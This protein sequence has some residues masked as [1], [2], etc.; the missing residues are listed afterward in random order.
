MNQ[1]ARLRLPLYVIAATITGLMLLP[2]QSLAQQLSSTTSTITQQ[3]NLQQLSFAQQQAICGDGKKDDREQCDPGNPN[4]TPSI[5]PD[6]AGQT[7]KSLK[8][9]EYS[10]NLLCNSP[11]HQYAC[12]FNTDGCYKCGNGVKEATEE[13]DDGNTN[14]GDG[15]SSG[16]K[17]E[18][19]YTLGL[20]NFDLGQSYIITPSPPN[21]PCTDDGYSCTKDVCNGQGLCIHPNGSGGSSSCCLS[22]ADCNDGNVCTNDTCDTSTHACSHSNNTASCSSDGFTCTN[23]VCSGGACAHTPGTGSSSCCLSNADCNDGN[24][25]TND[26]C[27]TTTHTCSHSNSTSSCNDGNACTTGDT[28]SAGACVP[29]ALPPKPSLSGTVCTKDYTFNTSTCQWDPVPAL[30]TAACSDSNAC[31]SGDHCNGT[32]TGSSACVAGSPKICTALDQCHN[33]GICNASTGTCTDPIKPYGSPCNDSNACTTG[34]SCQ[35]G[36]CTGTQ[37]NVDD[38]DSCTVDTCS[39]GGAIHALK[40]GAQCTKADEPDCDTATCQWKPYTCTVTAEPTSIQRDGISYITMNFSGHSPDGDPVI[41]CDITS[42]SPEA[43]SLNNVGSMQ[44]QIMGV[45]EGVSSVTV[46]CNISVIGQEKTSCTADVA[47]TPDPTC[48]FTLSPSDTIPANTVP[49]ATMTSKP[50]GTQCAL[51]SIDEAGA[52]TPVKNANNEIVFITDNTPLS[53]IDTSTAGTQTITVGCAPL[54]SASAKSIVDQPAAAASITTCSRNLTVAP[55]CDETSLL[56]DGKTLNDAV[57]HKGDLVNVSFDIA[58]SGAKSGTLTFDGVPYQVTKSQPLTFS[59]TVV[60]EFKLPYSR[61]L[62]DEADTIT[63]CDLTA[64]DI[65]VTSALCGDGALNGD[66][67]C[68]LGTAGNLNTGACPSCKNAICGDGFTQ[69]GVEECDPSDLTNRTAAMMCGS[70]C[71]LM[72]CGD[73]IEQYRIGEQCDDG[74]LTSSD[75]CNAQCQQEATCE[76]FTPS[77]I[78][79]HPGESATVVVTGLLADEACVGTHCASRSLPAR[80]IETSG[81]YT[82]FT[83]DS[84]VYRPIS[85]RSLS[86]I[87]DRNLATVSTDTMDTTVL[88][89]QLSS[90]NYTRVSS[91]TKLTTSDSGIS[92]LQQA[93]TTDSLST[94]YRVDRVATDISVPLDCTENSVTQGSVEMEVFTRRTVT[95]SSKFMCSGKVRYSCLP[96]EKPLCGDGKLSACLS[97]SKEQLKTLVAIYPAMADVNM[98]EPCNAAEAPLVDSRPGGL[99]APYRPTGCHAITNKDTCNASYMKLYDDT[100]LK[101]DPHNC[102]WGFEP[103]TG[104]E[105]CWVH[106]SGYGDNACKPGIT[107]YVDEAGCPNGE[108]GPWST[109]FIAYAAGFAYPSDAAKAQEVVQWASNNGIHEECDDGN[110]TSGDGCSNACKLEIITGNS[111]KII[112]TPPPPPPPP[113]PPAAAAKDECADFGYEKDTPEY[114]C[115]LAKKA[116]QGAASLLTEEEENDCVN[117]PPEASAP[118]AVQNQPDGQQPE[119]KALTEESDISLFCLAETTR[120][121]RVTKDGAVTEIE[122]DKPCPALDISDAVSQ[123]AWKTASL[124]TDVVN[125]VDHPEKLHAALPPFQEDMGSHL[126]KYVKGEDTPIKVVGA[127]LP[128]GGT[129]A[130]VFNLEQKKMKDLASQKMIE[131]DED[132]GSVKIL[133]TG[134]FIQAMEPLDPEDNLPA[135]AQPPASEQQPPVSQQQPPASQLPPPAN[136]AAQPPLNEIK[137]FPASGAANMGPVAKENIVSN[138]GYEEHIAGPS[139]GNNAANVSD[140]NSGVDHGGNAE[141]GN[142]VGNVDIDHTIPTADQLG[143]A[144]ANGNNSILMANKWEVASSVGNTA[145]L[146]AGI[147]KPAAIPV[148]AAAMT[149][150]QAFRSEG[151]GGGCTLAP[152]S[153][154]SSSASPAA[155]LIV[156]IGLGLAGRALREHL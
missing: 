39:E 132:G 69:A 118:P 127:K 1:R 15:C 76:S 84:S 88:T 61:A 154:P 52:V 19:C 74:N 36:T 134:N 141:A 6:L 156:L 35:G 146:T 102:Y 86:T 45:Q 104:K 85:A 33:A 83:R 79:L 100:G 58:S 66:E 3:I 151:G 143:S 37:V 120:A 136:N 51:V 56:I 138:P 11:T 145:A 95:E 93:R 27:N 142:G 68:D 125:N 75:G 59:H 96:Q 99:E 107:P 130:E 82:S 21:T 124:A 30:S 9:P 10:G 119:A 31:T 5:P 22:N 47:I 111:E 8:G 97:F 147:Q 87:Q 17:I 14:N 108:E 123:E 18:E 49:S 55:A 98:P 42:P 25:C 155:F 48:S 144:N 129:K 126:K 80:G 137:E 71:K 106:G 72:R 34:D 122:L 139:T 54:V 81:D 7:C 28:C 62:S 46:R 140:N 60:Q 116:A 67:Q 38:G 32:G 115:C 121:F 110:L 43:A 92:Q 133:D 44:Y 20:L 40:P 105:G 128:V 109:Q 77:E 91:G 135:S 70:D 26:T 152:A 16:C 50:D 13:C 65:P 101:S 23:D 63:E 153:G 78:A 90:G 41:M 113:P 29:G 57:I 89:S 2:N 64:Q 12:Q 53:V 131:V 112:V 24:A 4:T 103:G 94:G 148:N 150:V 117:P 114:T 149:V 73:G